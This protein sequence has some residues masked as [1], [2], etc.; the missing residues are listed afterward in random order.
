MTFQIPNYISIHALVKRATLTDVIQ[1]ITWGISIHALVK[2]ATL[3][4]FDFPLKKKDFNPRPREEGDDDCVKRLIL[5][6]N[7]NPRPREEGDNKVSC[8]T[9][10][11]RDFNPRPREEGDTQQEYPQGRYITI[12][13]HALVKRATP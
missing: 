5:A 8:F 9:P 3:Q 11:P 6:K 1:E 7:F 4:A 12:S 10:R 2:R 13:I